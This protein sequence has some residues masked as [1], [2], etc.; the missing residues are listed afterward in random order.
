MDKLSIK[1]NVH[2]TYETKGTSTGDD[3]SK[4]S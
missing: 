3:L 1:N 4:L 2:L